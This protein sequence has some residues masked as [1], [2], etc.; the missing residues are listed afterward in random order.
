MVFSIVWW[1]V[2]FMALPF[3]VERDDNPHPLHD[4]GA[5]KTIKLKKK[6]IITTLLSAALTA[7]ILYGITHYSIL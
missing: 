2:W 6:F 7:C 3:G 5:P 1:L 4:A